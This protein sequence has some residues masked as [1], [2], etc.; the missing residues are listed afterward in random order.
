MVWEK[1][2]E[3][4]REGLSEQVVFKLIQNKKSERY[5]GKRLPGLKWSLGKG[6]E[7]EKELSIVKKLKED[8]GCCGKD[9]KEGSIQR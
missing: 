4:V 9:S 3:G 1:I 2:V 8:L 6:P 7:V 5:D